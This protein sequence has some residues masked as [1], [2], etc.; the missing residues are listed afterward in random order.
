SIDEKNKTIEIY[1]FK[2]GGYHKEKWRSHATLYKY[3]LQLGF[4]KLLLNNSPTY[5]KYKVERAHI[6]FVSPDKD[7]EVYDKVYEFNDE[8]EKEL[9]SLIQ[10]VYRLISTLEFL[11]DERIFVSADNNL[12][13]KDI[14]EFVDLIIGKEN[15]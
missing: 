3:M 7:D 1:D 15:A 2:T 12:G 6:L 8:D 10:A 9:V 14:K 11:D 5:A 4:Y 13:L